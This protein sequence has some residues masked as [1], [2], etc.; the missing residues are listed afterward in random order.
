MGKP[1]TPD[2]IQR[3]R[4]FC[5]EQ[6]AEGE[7]F[8]TVQDA[9]NWDLRTFTP[10][11]AQWEFHTADYNPETSYDIYELFGSVADEFQI[12]EHGYDDFEIVPIPSSSSKNNTNITREELNMDKIKSLLEQAGVKPELAKSICESL[13]KYKETLREQFETDYSAKVQEAKK[14]CIE[15]TEA[16]KR[17]LARRLQIFCEA[18][19][20]AIEA[21]LAKQSALSESEALTKLK[22]VKAVL[23]GI[24]IDGEQSGQSTAVIERAKKQIQLAVEEKKRAI[25]A[26]NRQTAIAER[27]LKENRRLATEVAKLKE[28]S[29]VAESKQPKPQR[30]D[31]DRQQGKAVSTRATLLENQDPRPVAKSTQPNTTRVGTGNGFGINDIAEMV[32]EDLV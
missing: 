9:W 12:V 25:A 16:H 4:E 21:Q 29:V 24:A 7:P 22:S 32:D 17:D 13:V 5:R 15:E 8:F 31:K 6:I 28:T 30:L 20:A 18:K 19:G 1:I 2:Q 14:V 26:A 3:F 11:H 10:D 23:E 27:A